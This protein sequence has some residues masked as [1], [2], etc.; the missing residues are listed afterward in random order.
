MPVITGRLSDV[1]QRPISGLRPRMFWKLSRPALHG[2]TF[3]T[4]F[5]VEA[6]VTGDQWSVN[7]EPTYR[8]EFY[9]VEVEYYDPEGRVPTIVDVFP[10]RVQVGEAGGPLGE[11]PSATLSPESVWVGLEPPES[12]GYSWWL[13]ATVA[14]P[15]SSGPGILHV[16]R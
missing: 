10:Q 13:E 15:D 16:W 14:D 12:T 5:R 11:L 1:S 8:G 4:S 3:I 9:V 2:G 7:V 6:T